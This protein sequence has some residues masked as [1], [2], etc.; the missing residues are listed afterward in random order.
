V[1][2]AAFAQ[3]S[4]LGGE[5]CQYSQG[6]FDEPAYKTGLNLCSNALPVEE[7]A[8]ARRP[9]T[10]F[11]GFSR[12]GALGRVIGFDIVASAPYDFELTPGFLRVWQGQSLALDQA[13]AA[14]TSISTAKPAVLTVAAPQTW[15]SGDSVQI[16]LATD[17]TNYL[18]MAYLANR[19]F[20][21]TKLTT[22]T[23][24]LADQ[25]GNSLD[26]SLFA[27]GVTVATAG[28]IYEV[29]TPWADVATINTV[30]IAQSELQI[31]MFAYQT[32]T[33]LFTVGGTLFTGQK[34]FS[35]AA[36]TFVDGPYLDP[37]KDGS[38][39][40]SSG[41][42]GSVTLTFSVSQGFTSANIGQNIRLLSEPAPWIS[43]G[44][45]YV[46]GDKVKYQGV[47]YS[48]IVATG[49]VNN[50][51]VAINAW[52]IDETLAHWCY[53]LITAVTSTTV[54][55]AT[56]SN[57]PLPPGPNIVIA[58]GNPLLY[59]H[60]SGNP[61]T[62]YRMGLY[63]GTQ[64]PQNGTFHEGRFWF[65]GAVQNRVDSGMVNNGLT[66]SPTFYEGTVADDCGI[67]AVFNFPEVMEIESMAPVHQGVLCLCRSGEVLMQASQLGDPLT[68]TSIQA[69][70][71]SRYGAEKLDPVS[72]GYSTLF[73]QRYGKKVL[74]LTASVFSQRISAVNVSRD[75]RHLTAPGVT[76][77]RSQRELA[78]LI[79]ARS[80]N[81]MGGWIGMTYK[82]EDSYS[83]SAP[84][85][86]AWHRHQHGGQRYPKSITTGTVAGGATDTLAMLTEQ[87]NNTYYDYNAH[88]VEFLTPIF[89]EGQ[90]LATAW[91]ADDAIAP[92]SALISGTN[93]IFYGLWHILGRTVGVY[94]A[95]LDCGDYVVA[96]NGSVTVPFGA[97]DG[98]FTLA[99][100][101]SVSGGVN[102]VLPGTGADPVFLTQPAVQSY[103]DPLPHIV[104]WLGSAAPGSTNIIGEYDGGNVCAQFNFSS[105]AFVS[106][107]DMSALGVY[108][109]VLNGNTV[110]S[111]DGKMWTTND[112]ST[113][114][115]AYVRVDPSGS[116]WSV[117]DSWGVYPADVPTGSP[118]PISQAYLT[119]GSTHWLVQGGF[120]NSHI[121]VLRADPPAY[122]AGHF[123][124][125]GHQT[126]ITSDG[127]F[128]VCAGPQSAS[129]ATAYWTAETHA[130]GPPYK[131]GKTVI[132]SG[133]ENYDPSTWTTPNGFITTTTIKTYVPTDFDATWTT[134]FAFCGPA[135][136]ATDGHLLLQVRTTDVVTN[137]QYIVKVNSSTGAVIWKV[138]VLSAFFNEQAVCFSRI[139]TGYYFYQAQTS[140]WGG[141][142]YSIKTSDGTTTT[143]TYTG[144]SGL[145]EQV[146]DDVLG[147][148]IGNGGWDKA[149][150]NITLLNSTP[151]AG[152]TLVAI[153]FVTPGTAATN[154][155]LATAPVVIGF[156]FPSKGQL[157][158]PQSPEAS[159]ARNGP[160][161]GKTRRPHRAAAYLVN[162][163]NGTTYWG[164]DFTTVY[165]L[166]FESPRESDTVLQPF[167]GVQR[168]ELQGDYDYDGMIAWETSSLYPLAVAAIEGF[169]ETQD[170]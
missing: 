88:H 169:L 95:G 164:T 138:P 111:P 130:S 41:A 104:A 134:I 141:T 38:S 117:T 112:H 154:T 18:A 132:A 24:S 157:L 1:G 14:V 42:S 118:Y 63:W 119:M 116:P 126:D 96:T 3:N 87:P 162:A 106:R 72:V 84:L 76:E 57:I 156:R 16:V 79:W 78:P 4:F 155:I 93:V 90:S 115:G 68:P 46:A 29:A 49:T 66:C 91:Q 25:L 67:S 125:W 74:D 166:I 80:P 120:T 94:I 11:A 5:I 105:G 17:N 45:S 75:A 100:L 9:G 12:R 144:L 43:G 13:P 52:S 31:L 145:S 150:G 51:T 98:L 20:V 15:A 36:A 39:V 56:L 37:P 158:R 99:F 109:G 2:S 50:P 161:M 28:H 140:T 71:V 124:F 146:S 97:C 70:Q 22:T 170:I 133:A 21:L 19:Q 85:F 114:P 165:P 129:S 32:A 159:G 65:A 7:G 55:T 113:G 148:I 86:N 160:A 153:Y 127:S 92:V 53:A 48:C 33:Q 58:L 110:L 60:D 136:D 103:S 128:G 62:T 64:F 30:R 139:Q 73:V 152:G 81:A 8:W 6:R 83:S 149:Q 122:P 44:H 167:T 54:V 26:G 151:N 107:Q 34:S 163:I 10:Q 102:F 147:C 77:I 82:R 35:L 40:Q 123:G 89:Q 23:F 27:L 131:L 69:H 143:Q 59:T 47:Y 108:P 135:Y 101:E 121:T 142:A 168:F 137:K 61:I